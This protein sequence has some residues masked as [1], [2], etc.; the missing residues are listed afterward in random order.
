MSVCRTA[1]FGE[2]LMATSAVT[3]AA[4]TNLTSTSISST[5]VLLNWI[6]GDNNQTG[7]QID[8]TT[9]SAFT[10]NLTTFTA[11]A[12]ATSYSDTA[13]TAGTSYYYRVRATNSGLVSANCST[14][15]PVSALSTA[16]VPVFI[17]AGQSNMVGYGSNY[18][19]LSQAMRTTQSNVLY[20]QLQTNGQYQW[21]DLT[22]PT[23]SSATSSSSAGGFGPEITLGK[24]L[25][26][27]LGQVALVKST[28]VAPTSLITGVPA[29][30][31]STSAMV[32]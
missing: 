23:E 28:R 22:P 24:D 1:Q 20:Y 30:I 16:R 10:A 8:R 9:N 17:L 13:V 12:N 19:D 3:P 4:P 29:T 11:A 27:Y 31:P 5:Q 18:N 25:S 14:T 7:F 32:R 21:Q 2:S 6:N 15:G 26:T